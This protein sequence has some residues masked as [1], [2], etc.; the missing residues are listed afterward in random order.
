MVATLD[1]TFQPTKNFC[2]NLELD[3]VCSNSQRK[4]FNLLNNNTFFTLT[5]SWVMMAEGLFDYRIHHPQLTVRSIPKR[6]E[7][8]KEAAS[9]PNTTQYKEAL[10]ESQSYHW[11]TDPLTNNPLQPPIVSDCTGML[12]NKDAIIE[13]LL[14]SDDSASRKAEIEGILNGNVKGLK[15]VVEVKF[16]SDPDKKNAWICPV[17]NKPL[18]PNSKAVY[19][20]PCGHAF[21]AVV[22]TELK[23]DKCLTCGEPFEASDIIPILPIVE[24]DVKKLETRISSLREKGQTHSLK[25]ASGTK[26]RKKLESSGKAESKSI[27]KDS[28]KPAASINNNS[29]ASL[30]A[31]VLQEQ[32][33]RNKKRKVQKNDNISSLFSKE[34][35]F[36][37]KKN[38]FFTR[39]FTLPG[40]QKS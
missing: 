12:Y 10:K 32:E 13:L 16:E 1:L 5:T 18:G 21:A 17:T 7:L 20:V 11:T 27:T 6:R 28:E 8:V 33:E 40:Q 39:G 38:D 22:V 24:S 25:K 19:I 4:I 2:A 37:A 15:D 14:P 9:D 3:Y 23:E 34:S 30:T 35:D 29:T 36:S 31:K 26:K